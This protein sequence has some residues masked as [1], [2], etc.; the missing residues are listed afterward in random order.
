MFLQNNW[1][2]SGWPPRDKKMPILCATFA[3]LIIHIMN[4]RSENTFARSNVIFQYKSSAIRIHFQSQMI[5]LVGQIQIMMSLCASSVREDI[6]GCNIN[7]RQQGKMQW[8]SSSVSRGR[9]SGEAVCSRIR[10]LSWRV[11]E[12]SI[13]ARVLLSLSYSSSCWATCMNISAYFRNPCVL[14]CLLDLYTKLGVDLLHWTC[15]TDS[16]HWSFWLKPIRERVKEIVGFNPACFFVV[17]LGA[18]FNIERIMWFAVL[19]YDYIWGN[20]ASL[21][22]V[23]SSPSQC[24]FHHSGWQLCNIQEIIRFM[25]NKLAAGR[26]IWWVK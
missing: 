3:T 12:S 19:A 4:I 2:H 6:R 21:S 14:R 9:C 5:V 10:G 15:Y 22:H 25:M 7:I 16:V 17:K 13:T 23:M 18:F 26:R 8:W 20:I 11:T 24:K 1:Y